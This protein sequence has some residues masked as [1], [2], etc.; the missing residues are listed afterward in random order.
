MKTPLAWSNLVYKKTRTLVAVAGVAFAILLIFMQFGFYGAMGATANRFFDHLHF[1]ILLTST[2]YQNFGRPGVFPR[3]RLTEAQ[4]VEGVQSA[5]PLYIGVNLWRNPSW[6]SRRRRNIMVLGWNLDD[7]VFNLPEV[8]EATPR[9]RKLDSVLI[10]RRSRPEFGPKDPGVATELGLERVHIVG[11]FTLGTGF[12]ADGLVVASD[13]T[14]SRVFGGRSLDQVSL[15]LVQLRPGYDPQQVA[16]ELNRV[17]PMDVVA[18]TRADIE[19]REQN[20]WINR[21]SVGTIFRLGVFVVLVVGVVFVYQVISS[22]I[23]GHLGEYATLKAMGYTNTY[24]S[25]ILLQEALLLAGFAYVP[26]F[27]LALV[28]YSLTRTMA[29]IPIDMSVQRAVIVLL[30][31]ITMC[32]LS[33]FLALR[34]VRA[35]DPADLF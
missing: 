26:A 27:V 7:P 2:Q 18:R 9:L 11:Q 5:V 28:L 29:G 10:D 13:E 30:L 4:S 14:F 22:D 21:T 20:Y 32:A 24:L 34:K 23:A 3:I 6:E 19:E 16:Q 31:S 12:G 35:A 33:G 15:G 8:E 25:G 1:D 17:L